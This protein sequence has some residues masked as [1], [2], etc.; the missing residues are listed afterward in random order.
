M[1]LQVKPLFGQG[2]RRRPTRISTRLE[3]WTPAYTIT[4]LRMSI[5]HDE[6]VTLFFLLT[7]VQVE[8]AMPVMFFFQK[9]FVNV[10]KH[11]VLFNKIP[12]K[13]SIN[14]SDILPLFF[15]HYQL[16]YEALVLK[17]YIKLCKTN[18]VTVNKKGFCYHTSL[19]DTMT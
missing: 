2:I 7:I 12:L 9:S 17:I 6:T 10:I 8:S 4:A 16:L 15:R 1:P 18:A 19:P 14:V 11:F 13:H 5:E 3:V